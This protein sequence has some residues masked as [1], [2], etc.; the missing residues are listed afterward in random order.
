M[1]VVLIEDNP[2]A[3]RSFLELLNEYY[4]NVHFIGE[5]TNVEE[6]IALITINQPD[7][8]FLDIEMPDGTGFDLLRKFPKINFQVIF[9]SSHEKYALRAIKFSALDYLLKPIDPEELIEAIEKAKSEFEHHKTQQRVQTLINNINSQSKEPTQLVLKDKYGIQ[10]VAV[11]DIIHLEANGSYTIFF[12]NKQDSL[13]VSKGLKDYE[14]ILSSQQFFRCHQSHLINL[15]YLLRYD[16]RDGD[17]LI[18]K[19]KSKIP[20]AT[21]KKEILLKLINDL[22]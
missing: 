3:R 20:L 18:L 8:V 6:G 21:R 9:V 4:P 12:I 2:A 14:N 7:L 17:Y 11:K 16:K 15:D 22:N 5:A 1:K 19:D 10:I 13:L